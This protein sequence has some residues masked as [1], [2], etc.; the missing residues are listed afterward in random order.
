MN[1]HLQDD[2]ADL[3]I[4]KEA[5]LRS[6]IYFHLRKFLDRNN[7]WRVYS[8][9]RVPQTGHIIDLLICERSAK[10]FKPR[11]AIELKWNRTRIPDKDR[12]SLIKAIKQL[13]VHKAYFIS[14]NYTDTEY[15]RRHKSRH[16]KYKLFEVEIRLPLT[17][18]RK[19]ENWIEQRKSVKMLS[20]LSR[21][22]I[23]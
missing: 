23:N 15:Q 10:G 9:K 1:S 5:D 2:L 19:K 21:R 17:Q 6:C 16:E 8:E 13:H 14:T 22:K 18:E 3:H 7:D 20:E 4:I 11:L 12:K